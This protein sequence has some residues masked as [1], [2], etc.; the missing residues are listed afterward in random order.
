MLSRFT[1]RALSNSSFSSVTSSG[2]ASTVI[3]ALSFEAELFG[4]FEKADQNCVCL[5]PWVFRR[6]NIRCQGI[7]S[8]LIKFNLLQYPA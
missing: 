2:L 7:K 4:V 1:P 5:A 3:S 8:I 6:L